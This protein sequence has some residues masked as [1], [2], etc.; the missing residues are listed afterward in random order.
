MCFFDFDSHSLAIVNQ[1]L[2]NASSWDG[3]LEYAA[4]SV[5]HGAHHMAGKINK[6][7]KFTV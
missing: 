1:I 2:E 5:P 6:E 3:F 7:L 4:F